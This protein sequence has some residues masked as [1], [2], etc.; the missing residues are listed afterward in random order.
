MGLQLCQY[1]GRLSLGIEAFNFK[2]C[3]VSVTLQRQFLTTLL[4]TPQKNG[5]LKS[6]D[7]NGATLFTKSAFLF[8]EPDLTDQALLFLLWVTAF[9]SLPV[10]TPF[11]ASILGTAAYTLPCYFPSCWL[12]YDPSHIPDN[13]FLP[14]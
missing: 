1:L 2:V 5:S 9:S 4:G 10:L 3:A 8:Q 7:S 14:P 6:E 11:P 12:G 13:S